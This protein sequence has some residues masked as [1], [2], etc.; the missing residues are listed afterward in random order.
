MSGRLALALRILD[1][2]TVLFYLPE[3]KKE[4]KVLV[5]AHILSDIE[6]NI[7]N[8]KGYYLLLEKETDGVIE[9]GELI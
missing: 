5:E 6:E 3:E 8:E 4:L 9:Q 2:S 7:D 1:G